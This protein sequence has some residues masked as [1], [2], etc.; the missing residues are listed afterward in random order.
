MLF[1][2]WIAAAAA[3]CWC[4]AGTTTARAATTEDAWNVEFVGRSD[5]TDQRG[6][7]KWGEWPHTQGNYL[8]AGCDA[9]DRCFN[10]W[11]IKDP[12][13][14]KVAK[15]IY[16]YDPEASPSPPPMD[17][18]WTQKTPVDGWDPAWNTQTHFVANRGN[19]LIVNLER[20]RAGSNY[21]DNLRGFRVYDI[22]RPDDPKFLSQFN[23]PGKG[24]GTHHLFFDGNYVYLGAQYAGFLDKILVIVDVKDPRHPVEVGKWWIPG[25]KDVEEADI[26][27]APGGWV[28]STGFR[29]TVVWKGPF[30]D[31]EGKPYYLPYKFVGLHWLSVHGTRAYLSYHQAGVVILD[32]SD[33]ANPKFISRLDYHFPPQ[34]PFVTTDP[35]TN[36]HRGN[37]HAS[38]LVPGRNLLQVVDELQV[39]P[40]GWLRL[41]DIS[42]E[43]D[44][45]IV[46]EF[47][48]P[49]NVCP[50]PPT[51]GFQPYSHM[52]NSWGSNLLFIAW[53]SLGLR[54]VDISN[55]YD[56]KEVG[57]Y[58]PPG[59]G[60]YTGLSSQA[61]GYITEYRDYVEACD[62]VFGPGNLL[63]VNDAKGAGVYVLRYTGRGM[64]K[65]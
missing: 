6:I 11:D 5:P 60:W 26:R 54:V 46:S 9:P 61:N 37:T 27:A 12:E 38:K 33:K 56:P 52:A 22:S 15:T 41:I 45:I 3:L 31:K 2:R 53:P 10:V 40:Y 43:K 29:D 8:Y 49:G 25:Q 64:D 13:R 57:H 18:R 32:V 65:K 59:I 35:A 19:I 1:I 39:C 51:P 17:P 7:G 47:K 21:Q 63:Y 36:W 62:V 24:T 48:Y 28:Q 30:T 14:P 34:S 58:V 20:T 44:P 4:I 42:D 23:L 50:A 16:A 55:P